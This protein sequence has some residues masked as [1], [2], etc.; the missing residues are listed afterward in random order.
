MRSFEVIGGAFGALIR[1][2][3]AK[4]CLVYKLELKCPFYSVFCSEFFSRIAS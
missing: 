2:Q 3:E 4:K 1:S